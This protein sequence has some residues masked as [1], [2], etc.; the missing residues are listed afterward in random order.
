M[1]S[2]STILSQISILFPYCDVVVTVNTVTNMKESYMV[3]VMLMR[4][5]VV[6]ISSRHEYWDHEAV[7]IVWLACNMG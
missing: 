7:Q 3:T 6:A 5:H 4:H 2:L 1:L